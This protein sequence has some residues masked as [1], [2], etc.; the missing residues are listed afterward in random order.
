MTL[1]FCILFGLDWLH[2]GFVAMGWLVTEANPYKYT[3]QACLSLI[4]VHILLAIW[5]SFRLDV[6]ATIAAIWILLTVLLSRQTKPTALVVTIVVLLVVHPVALMG[7]LAWQR[8]K[9]REGRI[10]LEEEAEEAQYHGQPRE[11][12]VE[13]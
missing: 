10:R 13:E 8:T 1:F 2:N 6:Y 3:W 9:E 5:I 4:V 11:V 12:H 7:G